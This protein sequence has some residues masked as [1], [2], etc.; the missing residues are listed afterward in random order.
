[1]INDEIQHRGLA[2]VTTNRWVYSSLAYSH[3]TIYT[4]LT[5][6]VLSI[7]QSVAVFGRYQIKRNI[8]IHIHKKASI[9]PFLSAG[10]S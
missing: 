7:D 2:T 1:M 5:E 4:C 3:C 10:E 6:Y 9:N 8:Y